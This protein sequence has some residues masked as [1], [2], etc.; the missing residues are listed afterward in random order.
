MRRPSTRKR[1]AFGARHFQ[2]HMTILRAGSGIDRN[3]KRIGDPF[4]EALG[5]L[6]FDRFVIDVARRGSGILADTPA[7]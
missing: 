5:D 1:N 6:L 7:A 2:P 3:L 4:R